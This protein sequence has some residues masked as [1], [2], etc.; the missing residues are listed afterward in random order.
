MGLFQLR[1]KIKTLGRVLALEA[2]SFPSW[3]G[4]PVLGADGKLLGMVIDGSSRDSLAVSTPQLR[5]FLS[6]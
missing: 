6:R 5:T 3:R 1:G 4:G 2:P